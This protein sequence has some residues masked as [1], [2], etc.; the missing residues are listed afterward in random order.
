MV[1][2]IVRFC[3]SSVLGF[4]CTPRPS[5]HGRVTAGTIGRA[6]TPWDHHGHPPKAAPR[7]PTHTA[8]L[9]GRAFC[10]RKETRTGRSLSRPPLGKRGF[11]PVLGTTRIE[12]HPTRE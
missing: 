11:H 4:L 5:A 3:Q 12:H 9:A 10:S 1:R 8:V 2:P 7:L 6:T